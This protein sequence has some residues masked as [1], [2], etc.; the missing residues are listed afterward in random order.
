MENCFK[1]ELKDKQ[2]ELERLLPTASKSD[3]KIILETLDEIAINLC[4]ERIPGS[5]DIL[6]EQDYQELI[7]SKFLW[8][9]IEKISKIK[10]RAQE[11]EE[12]QF[13]LTPQNM[14]FNLKDIIDILHDFFKKATNKETYEIFQKIY[15]ENKKSIRFINANN[16]DYTG[17]LIYLEYFHKFY[18]MACKQN[19]LEDIM[20]F[21]HEFGHAIQFFCNFNSSLY[22][23]LNIYIEII[24]I[25]FELICNE[26]FQN[27]N[28]KESII[29]GY[30]TLNKH[31]NSSITLNSELTLLRAVQINS[32]E[33]ITNLRK[34]ID[35]LIDTLSKEDI[36]SMMMLRPAT[37]YIY[38]I[39]FNIATNLFMI[40][41]KD[42]DYALYLA[43]KIINIDLN[44]NKEEYY[45]ILENLGITDINRTRD[46]NNLL[47]TR[48]KKANN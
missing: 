19:E 38:V 17:E 39:A 18:I 29:T 30:N 47:L 8:D 25:F 14:Q 42:T 36:E 21:A 5:I 23:E 31:L 43:F 13:N 6:L 2:K 3:K 10:T 48:L 37:N 7:Q 28:K 32:N 4:K 1:N 12:K 22:K 46:Y 35:E 20:T 44:I 27:I 11:I 24:S 16:P 33:K 41:K 45:Q 34:N 40:Y 26:Y 9:Q 15:N